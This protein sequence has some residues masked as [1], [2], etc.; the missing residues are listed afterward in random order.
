MAAPRQ[1]AAA[2][3]PDDATR[4]PITRAGWAP[5]VGYGLPWATTLRLWGHPPPDIARR[6]GHEP[7]RI[8]AALGQAMAAWAGERAPAPPRPPAQVVVLGDPQA[9][10][11]T[12]MAH[13][14]AQDLLTADG[15]LRP[16]IGV[17][18]VGDYCDYRSEDPV[19]A[20][21]DGVQFL[22][23]LAAHDPSQVVL[24]LG[25]HDVERVAGAF[26]GVTLAQYREAQAACR[27]ITAARHPRADL[28]AWVAAHPHHPPVVAAQD[29]VAYV[30]AQGD[31][32]R[33]LL[34]TG[35]LRLAA[36][37]TDDTGRTVLVTHAGVT[38]REQ[39]LLDHPADAV[40]WASALN[41]ALTTAVERVRVAWMAQQPMP[42]DLAPLYTGW[43]PTR[44]NGGLLIGRPD[45]RAV[46][47]ADHALA[48][49]PPL[50]PRRSPPEAY[51]LPGLHQVVGHTVAARRLVLW[52]APHV[53]PAALAA[54]P[55]AV[56]WLR[57]TA[58]GWCLDRRCAGVTD[59]Q[60][61]YTCVDVAMLTTAPGAVEPLVVS[62]IA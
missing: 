53:T 43:A 40:A 59:P 12:L 57:S 35:R 60:S 44:P 7:N 32:I 49:D 41:G 14:A 55:G 39:A 62:C 1:H 54:P 33:R 4:W 37:A 31:L 26:A 18:C 45:A 23:W 20:G 22:A 16:D 13:L 3:G 30:P 19:T 58:A 10:L 48:L 2:T 15:W 17:L 27:V 25:N 38:T 11:R 5:L 24:L 34:L 8:E 21:Y 42:L 50:A 29:Y 52:L 6:C 47:G 61:S 51:L 36:T 28:D 56:L 9:P 46:V